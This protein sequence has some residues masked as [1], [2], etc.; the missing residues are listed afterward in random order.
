M[1]V[2]VKQPV[3][4]DHMGL[5]GTYWPSGSSYGVIGIFEYE[6]SVF[7]YRKERA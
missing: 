2:E 4:V 1:T 5:Q 6:L 3:K 7:A